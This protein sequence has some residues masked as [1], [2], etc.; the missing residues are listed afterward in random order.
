MLVKEY[1]TSVSGKTNTGHTFGANLCPDTGGLDPVRDR[2]EIES[3]IL[4]SRA[5]ALLEYLKTL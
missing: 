1:D 2:Q 4:Q 5:G 3:R